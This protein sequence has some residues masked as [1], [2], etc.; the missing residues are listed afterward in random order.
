[1]QKNGR[2]S[3]ILVM[4]RAIKNKENLS[5]RDIFDNFKNEIRIDLEKERFLLQKI[6]AKLEKKEHVF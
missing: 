1:M 4:G 2:R 6:L 5:V 3:S